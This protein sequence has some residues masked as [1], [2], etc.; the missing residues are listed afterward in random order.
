MISILRLVWNEWNI[1]H[2]ARHNVI[3]DEVE[4]VCHH[5]PLVQ[6]GKKGRLL[7]IGFTKNG[8]MLTV[9]LDPEEE[10]GVYYPVTA[11]D[12]SRKEKRLYKQEK[13]VGKQ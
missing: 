1:K 10:K 12:S 13:E 9:V 7:I 11:R 8:R 5:D 2:I 6:E 3:S 4:E